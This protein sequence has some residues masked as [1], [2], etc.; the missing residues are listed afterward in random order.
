MSTNRRARASGAFDDNRVSYPRSSAMPFQPTNMTTQTGSAYKAAI[1]A[2]TAALQGA[3][4]KRRNINGDG[5][6]NQLVTSVALSGSWQYVLDLWEAQ[7]YTAANSS[8][9]FGQI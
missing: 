2:D 5:L 1:D 4:G 6:V 9:R 8:G 3:W 7:S